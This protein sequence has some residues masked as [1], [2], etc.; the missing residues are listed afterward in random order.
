MFRK[1]NEVSFCLET[2]KLLHCKQQQIH[3]IIHS[4]ECGTKYP[5]WKNETKITSST[6]KTTIIH[7]HYQYDK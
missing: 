4:L 7:P 1:L 3:L 6:V 2:S 5:K